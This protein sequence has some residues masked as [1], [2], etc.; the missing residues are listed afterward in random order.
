MSRNILITGADSG[1]GLSIVRRFAYEKN[2]L[3][4]T[5]KNAERL[6]L[7]ERNLAPLAP[8]TSLPLDLN[9]RNAVINFKSRIM[10]QTPTL[11]VLIHTAGVYHD[12]THVL[13][14]I[15]FEKF[16]HEQITETN[17][18]GVFSFAM[19][20]RDLIP[21]MQPSSSI[22]TISGTFESARGWLPY[23]LSKKSLESLT[24]GLSHELAP[25]RITANCVSPADTLTES[26]QKFFPEDARPENCLMPE[27]V[28]DLV[29]FLSSD[30]ARYITGQIIELRKN[31]ILQ[32]M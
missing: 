26:Y 20:C 24:V 9:D 1:I 27:D 3:I 23:Y 21:L 15:E 31:P 6:R 29:H 32:R 17:N 25:R 13:A 4:L 19:M 30:R 16:S 28:A 8:V 7:I 18:V 11:D 5:A 12:G 22:I 2:N 10:T 14:N